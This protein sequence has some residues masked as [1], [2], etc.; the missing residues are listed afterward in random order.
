MDK[1]V[2]NSKIARNGFGMTLRDHIYLQPGRCAPVLA[3][4]EG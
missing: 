1:P 2:W 4:F 3:D